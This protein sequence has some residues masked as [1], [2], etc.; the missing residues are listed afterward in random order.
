MHQAAHAGTRTT[1]H[2]IDVLDNL[3]AEMDVEVRAC[4]RDPV[5]RLWSVML[6]MFNQVREAPLTM[7]SYRRRPD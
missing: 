1:A 4:C 2:L 5:V 7:S 6:T 3:L